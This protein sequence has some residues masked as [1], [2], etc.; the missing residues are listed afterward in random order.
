MTLYGL[1]G[2]ILALVDALFFVGRTSAFCYWLALGGIG[3]VSAPLLVSIGCYVAT[4]LFFSSLL[5]LLREH[6]VADSSTAV[7]GSCPGGRQLASGTVALLLAGAQAE[8]TSGESF[9]VA[10]RASLRTVECL[11]AFLIAFTGMSS[12]PVLLNHVGEMVS[13]S[14]GRASAHRYW[15]RASRC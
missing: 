10:L 9:D 7:V 14:G 2:S 13:A 8:G 4:L 11:L 6:V 12:D 15:S 1:S 3:G 5:L